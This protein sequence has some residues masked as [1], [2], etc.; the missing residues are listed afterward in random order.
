MPSRDVVDVG[1]GLAEEDAEAE[2]ELDAEADAEPDRVGVD[3]PAA[4]FAVV[5]APSSGAAELVHPASAPE[6]TNTAPITTVPT[7]MVP[8]VTGE[9][10]CAPGGGPPGARVFGGG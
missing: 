9:H 10:D 6:I 5:A 4:E 3:E 8:T 1:F 2:P 7:R